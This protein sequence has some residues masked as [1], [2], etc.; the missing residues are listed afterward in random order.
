MYHDKHTDAVLCISSV[1]TSFQNGMILYF[2]CPLHAN[3]K[4]SLDN[5][6]N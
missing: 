6:V 4:V 2:K 3:M 5:Q 1:I